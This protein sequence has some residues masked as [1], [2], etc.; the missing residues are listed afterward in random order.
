[1]NSPQRL[2]QKALLRRLDAAAASFDD[3]DF[4]HEAARE[5]LFARLSPMLLDA[6]VVLDLG[7]ATG[8]AFRPLSKR[9]PKSQVIAVDFSGQMARKC[10][11]RRRFPRAA[12]AVQADARALPFPDA[13]V[14]VVFSNLMLPWIDDPS[15]VAAEVGR[16]LRK[17]GLFA[18]STL[19]PDSFAVL[20]E[21]F[22]E[23]SGDAS[24][25]VREF[26][27]MH[28]IGDA[29]VRA[30]LR[31]PVLDVDRL[32]V[33]YQ[34]PK[35][36]FA[37]LTAVGARNVFKTRPAGLSGRGRYE[38]LLASLSRVSPISVDFELVFGHAW[39]SGQGGDRG[40]VRI[41]PANISVRRS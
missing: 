16:V 36:L 10:R 23:V 24:S 6:K 39:G 1:M 4:V 13:S 31:D 34:E 37:D 12:P 38:G 30:G 28:D 33:S 40:A 29:L 11:A 14:D 15:A 41:D 5:G 35:R 32:D 2:D 27:D 9:F 26:A 17:D 19:G 20:R 8:A 18:F 7:A 22:A 3:A 25:H 21:A